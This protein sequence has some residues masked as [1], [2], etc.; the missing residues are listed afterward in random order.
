MNAPAD[1]IA[2]ILTDSAAAGHDPAELLARTAP[3]LTV[4]RFGRR[5]GWALLV[6]ALARYL[7]GRRCLADARAV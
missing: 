3:S 2:R 5:F 4:E 7:I 1:A 6:A